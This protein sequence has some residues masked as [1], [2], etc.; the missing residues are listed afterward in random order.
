MDEPRLDRQVFAWFRERGPFVHINAASSY[1]EV[2]DD[3]AAAR[4]ALRPDGI[5]ACADYG[6]AHAAAAVWEAVLNG[7]LRPICVS[8]QT[9]YGTWGDP[10]PI[11]Q[12]L[13]HRLDDGTDQRYEIQQVMGSPLIRITRPK[14]QAPKRTM[15]TALEREQ[16]KHLRTKEA[17]RR[18]RDHLDDV[19]RSVSY[20]VGRM[21]TAPPRAIRRMPRG[22][23]D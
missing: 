1:E 20:R 23:S 6:S 14:P 19:Q 9:F 15:K 17:L 2:R 21:L 8:A 7:E 3:L 10:V 13:L 18:K 12:E 4:T 22:P 5:V 11:Q 16:E